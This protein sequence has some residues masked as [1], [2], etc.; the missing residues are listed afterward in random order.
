MFAPGP[1]NK[2]YGN[3]AIDNEI[4][5]NGNPGIALPNHAAPAGAPA[6]NLN[7]N[8]IADNR[9]AGNG[10]TSMMPRPRAQPGSTS[11]AWP[12]SPGR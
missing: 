5:G 3:A 11:T 12:L 7:D 2:V 10:P 8:L 4:K 9:I 6:V 1:G